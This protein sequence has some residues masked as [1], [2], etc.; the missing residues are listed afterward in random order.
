MAI[1]KEWVCYAH[2]DFDAPSLEDGSPPP[3]PHG[4]GSGM[5]E[6]VFR[7]APALQSAGYRGINATFESLA[8]E[9]GLT[10][11]NNSGRDGMRRADYATHRRLNSATEM[12]M[13]ASRSGRQGTDAS[14]FFKPLSGFQPGSTGDGGALRRVGGSEVEMQG[15]GKF[16]TGGNLV[17]G[18]IPLAR[19]T[20]IPTASFDG[21][22][23]GLPAGDA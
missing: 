10:D 12:I 13:G 17:A 21:T 6:R 23:L 7:T 1:V 18:E 4:C 15:G 3:C 9:H 19:P 8:R 14:E 11:M 16:V 5:V 20:A 22:K 2:G